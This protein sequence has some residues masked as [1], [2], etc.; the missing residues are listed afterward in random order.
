MIR[1]SE[2]RDE[3]V[4]E[5]FRVGQVCLYSISMIKLGEKLEAFNALN[6][7]PVGISNRRQ[8]IKETVQTEKK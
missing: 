1:H 3:R 7:Q 5:A 6:N 8:L 2:E 4:M